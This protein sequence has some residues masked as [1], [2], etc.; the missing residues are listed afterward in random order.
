MTTATHAPPVAATSRSLA[1]FRDLFAARTWKSTAH[2]LGNLAVGVVTFT[3]TLPALVGTAA[4]VPL[5][6]AAVLGAWLLVAVTRLLGRLERLRIWIFLDLD[7]PYPH[8]DDRALSWWRRLWARVGRASTWKE[9]AILVLALPVGAITFSL[10]LAT[11]CIPLT[12][13][14]L[15]LYAWALPGDRA[16]LWFM[17]I[18]AGWPSVVAAL[19]GAVG[20]LFVPLVIRLLAAL[21]G[22]LAR[23][24]LG[25]SRRHALDERVAV[26]ETSRSRVV[27]AAEAERRR[28]E[29]D[30]HDG[31]QQR[32]VAL[33]M[34]LGMA[35]ERLAT[36]PDKARQLLDEAHAEAKQALT[37]LRNLARGIHPAVLTDRGL[38]AALSAVAAR[39]PVPVDLRVQVGARPGPNVESI[40]YFVVSESL[41]NVAKH[42]GA[43][44]ATVQVARRGNRLVIEVSDNGRG[45]ADPALGTGLAGLHDRVAGVDGWLHVSSPL[46]GPTTLLVELPCGS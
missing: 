21:N 40:A 24:F 27:D 17:T 20:L 35:R 26:L 39:S 7:I 1:P 14:T 4:S 28:I 45:G 22:R 36:D 15:P 41:A 33:A 18:G 19:I 30:L 3:I 29:R 34:D 25:P 46:G 13:L 23:W 12:L 38:D 37:E 6:P 44:R 11:W 32:L 43:T 31:A 16:D 2:L 5:F 42:S 10:A 8:P 9:V